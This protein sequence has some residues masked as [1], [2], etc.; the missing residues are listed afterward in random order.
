LADQERKTALVILGASGDLT[1]RKLG[2]ALFHLMKSGTLPDL[3]S[4]TGVARSDF[5]DEQFRDLLREGVGSVDDSDWS[6]FSERVS[7]FQ[8]SST[9][10]ASL[11]ELDAQ[12]ATVCGDKFADDRVCYL[13]LK[14]SLYPD[15]LLA[16]AESRDHLTKRTALV[17]S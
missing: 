3:C 8:G 12:I 15:T 16:L 4:F 6:K 11:K 10:A 13:A 1:Q 5:S 17:G 9:D 2:P 7:Y 14:P